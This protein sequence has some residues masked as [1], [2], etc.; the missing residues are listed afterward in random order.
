MRA[1]ADQAAAGLQAATG[2]APA[3][4]AAAA[5]NDAAEA[6]SGSTFALESSRLVQAAQPPPSAAQ[7]AEADAL[8]QTR[9]TGL[10]AALA[11]LRAFVS[12][13]APGDEPLPAT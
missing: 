2:S 8:V 4:D 7:L 13:P 9:K 12:P 1:T 11:R 10:D 5:A 6:L 3:P